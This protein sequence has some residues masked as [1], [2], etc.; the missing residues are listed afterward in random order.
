[1]TTLIFVGVKSTES[2]I[3][4]CYKGTSKVIQSKNRRMPN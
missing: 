3:P 1:M 2:L 4:F